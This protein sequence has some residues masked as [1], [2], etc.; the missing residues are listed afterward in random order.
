VRARTVEE[1]RRWPILLVIG[2]QVALLLGI[3]LY[4]LRAEWTALSMTELGTLVIG[5]VVL[6]GATAAWWRWG[7]RVPLVLVDAWLAI[8]GLSVLTLIGL[9]G[10][11]GEIDA[12]YPVAIGLLWLSGGV[13]GAIAAWRVRR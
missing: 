5:P 12:S 4:A 6:V 7:S 10:A 3:G 1:P 13:A 2:A 9:A 11:G 8:F